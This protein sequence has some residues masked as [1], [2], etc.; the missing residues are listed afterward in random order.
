MEVF[1]S[2]RTIS[3]EILMK[4]S[5]EV[6]PKDRPA[7]KCSLSCLPPDGCMSPLT[8]VPELLQEISAG[9]LAASQSCLCSVPT[10]EESTWNPLCCGV[11]STRALA[12]PCRPTCPTVPKVNLRPFI[13]VGIRFQSIV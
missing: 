1:P 2:E 8:F 7:G 9:P 4:N 12:A 11:E 13:N 10:F 6:T 5:E 3:V